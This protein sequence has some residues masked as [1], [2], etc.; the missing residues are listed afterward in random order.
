[1]SIILNEQN[2]DK[3]LSNNDTVLVKFSTKWCQPCKRLSPILDELSQ[4]VNY[5]IANVDIE[6]SPSLGDDYEVLSVPTLMVFKKGELVAKATGL[7][8]KE[9]IKKLVENA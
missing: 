2:F 4:E 5:V 8:S 3:T 1:M 7:Q 6:E 9:V